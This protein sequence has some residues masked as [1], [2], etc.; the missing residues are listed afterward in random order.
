VHL[1]CRGRDRDI[2]ARQMLRQ[3]LVEIVTEMRISDDFYLEVFTDQD[4]FEHRDFD[5]EQLERDEFQERMHRDFDEDID[6]TRFQENLIA[7]QVEAIQLAEAERGQ[8][9][10]VHRMTSEERGEESEH[11]TSDSRWWLGDWEHPLERKWWE[12][13]EASVES[14]RWSGDV[15]FLDEYK[16]VATGLE[17]TAD[18][19]MKDR[20]LVKFTHKLVHLK[21]RG[22]DRDILARH[23]LRQ[24]LEE[25]ATEM[26]ISDDEHLASFIER[27]RF[28][29]QGRD[30]DLE[31]QERDEFRERVH[32]DFDEDIDPWGSL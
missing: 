12:E 9:E 23:M 28:E 16:S 13:L 32:R 31:R 22:R 8:V 11:P 29:H 3:F 26:Q 1:K 15:A 25:I 20:C 10:A 6:L 19:Q 17:V 4:R 18:N 21:C 5:R 14:G 27:D 2:L 30:F 7:A 24:F